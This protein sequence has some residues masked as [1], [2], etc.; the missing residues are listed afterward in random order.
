MPLYLISYELQHPDSLKSENQEAIKTALK[1]LT[2][3]WWSYAGVTLIAGRSLTPQI[4]NEKIVPFL[5]FKGFTPEDSL[6]II[7]V[8]PQSY[9]GWLPQ[10]A[11][12]WIEQVKKAAL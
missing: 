12:D 9:Y 1:T 7:R 2:G 8:D 4:I 10:Q 5:K 3:W 6:F 11:W